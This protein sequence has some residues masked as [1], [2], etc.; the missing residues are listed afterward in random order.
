MP[1]FRVTLIFAALSG[2]A[3]VAAGAFAAHGL[4]QRLDPSLLNAF[5]TGADYQLAH[6]IVL[7]ALALLMLIKP[8]TPWLNGS[9]IAFMFG[10][11]LFSG[12]LYA[13][14]L[15]GIGKLGIITPF[16]GIALIIGWI[17]LA[18]AAMKVVQ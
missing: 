14:S 13:L 8:A 12:G 2:A 18:A 7:L 1:V 16:G 15:S 11:A 3:S 17:M 6:S 9:A 10:I 5:K 4:K